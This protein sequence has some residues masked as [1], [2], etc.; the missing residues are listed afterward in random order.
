VT[1]RSE[2]I[3]AISA[4]RGSRGV[5]K[6]ERSLAFARGSG[7]NPQDRV[8]GFWSRTLGRAGWAVYEGNNTPRHAEGGAFGGKVLQ[9]RGGGIRRNTKTAFSRA[10]TEFKISR[11]E[12]CW[13]FFFFFKKRGTARPNLWW[14]GQ[15][16]HKF[17]KGTTRVG[18]T[19]ADAESR[20]KHG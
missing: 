12:N 4:A 10:G 14:T 7:K 13:F 19:T 1:E 11:R 16:G 8:K 3:F 2:Y 9:D 15:E 6:S 17:V 5:R 20:E 18:S